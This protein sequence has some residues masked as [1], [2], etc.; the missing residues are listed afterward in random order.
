MAGGAAI[1]VVVEA[2][3]LAQALRPVQF[4]ELRRVAS[5]AVRLGRSIAGQ[6]GGVAGRAGQRR[7]QEEPAFALAGSR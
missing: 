1:S 7:H 2:D 4:A 5:K 3:A 6:A